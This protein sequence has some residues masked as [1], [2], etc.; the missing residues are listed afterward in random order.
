MHIHTNHMSPQ[1]MGLAASQSAQRA[2]D[3]RKAAVAVRRKL[4]LF[5]DAA[6]SD[7]IQNIESDS[8]SGSREEPQ[9]ED[10]SFKHFFS[11]N[12]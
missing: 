8:D 2:S 9:S 1:T 11:V 6:D 10:D 7:R 4:G 5:A 3:A 12:A